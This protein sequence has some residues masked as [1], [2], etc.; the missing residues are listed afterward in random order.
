MVLP[1]IIQ[2]LNVQDFFRCLKM[3]FGKVVL[4]RFKE[5]HGLQDALKLYEKLLAASRYPVQKICQSKKTASLPGLPQRNFFPRRAGQEPRH[6]PAV[7]R[8]LPGTLA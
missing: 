8:R 3:F 4:F 2:Y 7:A 6:L 5:F 1:V